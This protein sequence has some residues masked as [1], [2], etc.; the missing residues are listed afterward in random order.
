MKYFTRW[1]FEPG[2]AST[3]FEFGN[4]ELYS[5][6]WDRQ[7]RWRLVGNILTGYIAIGRF[8]TAL[9]FYHPGSWRFY[10]ILVHPTRG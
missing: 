6:D 7:E 8:R 4:R 9:K 1:G 2:N 5:T 3:G 10:M